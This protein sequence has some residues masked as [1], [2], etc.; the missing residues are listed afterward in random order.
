MIEACEVVC[1]F[2][3]RLIIPG[4][5]WDI[6]HIEAHAN[7]GG[8]R[9]YM[10]RFTTQ[11]FKASVTR[12]AGKRAPL[13]TL[14]NYKQFPVGK[15]IEW[16][17]QPDGLWCKWQ[18]DLKSEAGAEA[19]RQADEGFVTGLSVG[20]AAGPED[21]VEEID[22][23]L[24]VTRGP[25]E[26]REVSLVSVPAYAD[27]TVEATRTATPPSKKPTGNL[28]TR[29]RQLK[30]KQ[31]SERV[32]LARLGP[33]ARADY[34]RITLQRFHKECAGLL[35]QGDQLR[36]NGDGSFTPYGPKRTLIAKALDL[37]L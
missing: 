1:H 19:F 13:L 28:S 3:G 26:L 24:H 23:Q 33:E 9:N 5:R 6:D 10:E 30:A 34:E 7:G 8:E 12:G 27:A 2:C 31:I 21:R 18:L 15:P 16:D 20:F 35:Y 17:I 36:L 29:L 32:L 11:T 4:Q 25:A 14:H 22:D 37:G